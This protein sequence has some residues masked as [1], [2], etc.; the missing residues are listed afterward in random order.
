MKGKAAERVTRPS[1]VAGA[2]KGTSW[3]CLNR[4]GIIVCG[5]GK[6]KRSVLVIEEFHV[7]SE[8]DA[9]ALAAELGVK[10]VPHHS[11]RVK[12]RPIFDGSRKKR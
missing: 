10:V 5:K 11:R 1:R 9:K 3:A 6:K 2:I 4:I 8:R 7:F 12:N